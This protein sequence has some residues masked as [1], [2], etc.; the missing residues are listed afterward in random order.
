MQLYNVCLTFNNGKMNKEFFAFVNN[1]PDTFYRTDLEGCL[2]FISPSVENLL[3]YRL[4]ELL[5]TRLA[6]LYLEKDQRQQF[7]LQLQESHGKIINF[8]APLRHRNGSA[9][10]VSTSASYYHDRDGEIAGVEGITRDITVNKKTEFQLEQSRLQ[11]L[12]AEKLAAVGRLTASFAHEFNNPV[13][14]VMSVISGIRRRAELSDSDQKLVSMALQECERMKNMIIDLQKFNKPSSGQRIL[15]DV[16]LAFEQALLLSRDR[17]REGKVRLTK[18]LSPDL[19]RIWAL[20]D[21]IIQVLI[22]FL[23]NADDALNPEGGSIMVATTSGP[24]DNITIIIEDSGSGIS[25]EDQ[26]HIFEPFFTT[27]A[28]KGMGLGLSVSYGIIKS[29]GGEIKVES[30]SGKGTTFTI[31]I[32]VGETGSGDYNK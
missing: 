6:D 28:V 3:G 4:E 27:K 26:K 1:L 23:A 16:N 7:L 10:W 5:G 18:K 12:H 32:P 2:L 21:Q 14:G 13:C 17:L 22:N 9:V 29:H 8:Q 30:E 25:P 20:P 15:M 31:V 11:L 24:E 19:P